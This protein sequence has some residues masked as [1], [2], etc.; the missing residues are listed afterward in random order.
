MIIQLPL[1][2][3][4][5]VVS[6]LYCAKRHLSIW[7][8]PF[9]FNFLVWKRFLRD[10]RSLKSLHSLCQRQNMFFYLIQSLRPK[11]NF[12]S[13]RAKLPIIQVQLTEDEHFDRT[14]MDWLRAKICRTASS[15]LINLFVHL[16]FDAGGEVRNKLF[17]YSIQAIL[18]ILL[19][20]IH[21][22]WYLDC[23][24]HSNHCY[25]SSVKG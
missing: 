11:F 1:I 24:C 23:N 10:S 6:N 5:A 16:K 12:C 19:G 7:I 17:N 22:I 9:L 25:S 14:K 15:R 4:E 18:S 20:H 3:E 8:N 21:S 2:S 13:Q